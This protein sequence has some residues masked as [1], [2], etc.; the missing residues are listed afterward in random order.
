MDHSKLIADYLAGPALLRS[1]VAGMTVEQLNACPVPGKWST[2]QV[3]CH[4]ADFEPVYIDRMKRVIAEE[5]PTMFGG[6]PD[7]FAARLSYDRR[8]IE[9]ELSLIAATR[10]HMGPILQAL[11]PGDFLRTGNHSEAG[12]ITLEKLLSNITN[13]IPHHI[14]FINEKRAALVHKGC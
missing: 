6:D 11:A 3:V 5:G 4:I 1:A 12:L 8:D 9:V 2:K 7:L 14:K 10:A 13:H